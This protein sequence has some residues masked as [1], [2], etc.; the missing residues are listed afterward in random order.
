ME[1]CTRGE[2]V[3]ICSG[4][5][6]IKPISSLMKCKYYR[7]SLNWNTERKGAKGGSDSL[8]QVFTFGLQRL[9]ET[10][11]G[12]K[13]ERERGRKFMQTRGQFCICLWVPGESR[14]RRSSRGRRSELKTAKTAVF[15]NSQ[16]QTGKMSL[17]K[18]LWGVSTGMHLYVR[19]CVV[20]A[21][22][23]YSETTGE[24]RRRVE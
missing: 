11:A 23:W 17:G 1:R 24:K 22:E 16:Q 13:R 8:F 7:E 9:W 6:N 4:V 2:R 5:L 14:R 3:E 21:E 20:V 18:L 19:L 12:R 10:G 15:P